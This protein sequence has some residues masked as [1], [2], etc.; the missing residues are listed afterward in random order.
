MS[1]RYWI[2]QYI[3]DLFR[4]EPKNVGVFVE[5]NGIV[6]ARF[7]GETEPGQIDSRRIK[8]FRFPSVYKQWVEY[9]RSEIEQIEPGQI[10]KLHGSH[11]RVVEGGVIDDISEDS[12]DD[13]INYL[14]SRL[15]S[16]GGFAEA[17]S[18][19]EEVTVHFI[20]LIKEIDSVF[21]DAGLLASN[22][23]YDVL[24]PIEKGIPLPSKSNVLHKPDYVQ[25]NGQIFVMDIIDFTVSKKVYARDHAGLSAY[26]FKDLRESNNK[27]MPI[28]L[29]KATDEDKEAEDVRYALSL[30]KN[31][32]EIVNWL[33]TE[34]RNMF[35]KER[36]EV[37]SSTHNQ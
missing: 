22:K 4:R 36:K 12:I 13:V 10:T 23:L 28:A 35:I 37:A 9:W 16:E 34:E 26:K 11:Y 24:H 19:Q 17:I 15:I 18:T 14:Y 20:N 21:E 1:T 30:L 6:A 2:A 32:G 5:F 3:S 29:I 7:I 27:I 25:R 31:E 8:R 33:K